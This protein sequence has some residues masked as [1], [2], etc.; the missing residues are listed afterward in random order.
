MDKKPLD[1]FFAFWS[2]DL[3]P[4]MLGGKTTFMHKDGLVETE[5]FTGMLFRPFKILPAE[6]GQELYGK[7]QELRQEYAEAKD[8]LKT[9]FD[10]KLD[11]L[12]GRYFHV[13][14]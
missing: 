13:P 6:T 1:G 9:E 5:G 2:Y 14:R 8:K 7:I 10:K 3:Y 12:T 11:E 4:Y